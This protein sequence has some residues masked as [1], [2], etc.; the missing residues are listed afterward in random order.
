MQPGVVVVVGGGD[1]E[2][3][4]GPCIVSVCYSRDHGDERERRRR[5][6]ILAM[7]GWTAAVQGGIGTTK[8]A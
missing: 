4:A 1:A 2:A 5:R 7:D 6:H 8:K 3:E